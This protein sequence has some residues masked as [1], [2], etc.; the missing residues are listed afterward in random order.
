L[1]NI[2][3]A[4][5]I[6]VASAAGLILTLSRCEQNPII[7]D[8][9]GSGWVLEDTTISTMLDTVLVRTRNDSTSLTLY[10][11]Q[12]NDEQ[13]GESGILI[14]FASVDTSRLPDLQ[15]ATLFLFRR[16][17]AD[18]PP[19]L[20]VNFDLYVID[21]PD[22]IWAESETGLTLENFPNLTLHADSS[23]AVNPATVIIGGVASDSVLEHLA[24]PVNTDT[25][26]QWALGHASNN[27]F[28]IRQENQGTLVGF[29]SG[30][31]ID[32]SP[33]LA[34][35]IADTTSTGADT[36][37]TQYYP[38]TGDLSIYPPNPDNSISSDSSLHLDHSSGVRSHIDFGNI[39]MTWIIAGARLIL[40]ANTNASRILAD[41]VDLQILRRTDSLAEGNST[42]L[43]DRSYP[44]GSDSL[45]IKLSEFLA[46]VVS[47]SF[48]NYGLDLVVIPN[49]H[50]F[51]HLAFW[52]SDADSELRPRLEVTYS[53][54]YQ[55]VP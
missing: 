23:M 54:L 21:E 49:N 2:R 41:Q 30:E 20:G 13:D 34:L 52:G 51:D 1:S 55:E 7:A 8:L 44:A 3:W 27:G 45:N 18:E 40:H 48:E 24:F 5:L 29:Y 17:F 31:N 25:L 4:W 39:D 53:R 33:Y 22:T 10:A 9:R 43:L 19:E 46:G 26:R 15:A 35:T 47:G 37:I 28:L 6:P 36:T 16:T 38:P 12:I 32:L 11:G 50:D 14:K 42:V